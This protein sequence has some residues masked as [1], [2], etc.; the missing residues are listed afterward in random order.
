VGVRPTD[1]RS[2]VEHSRLGALPSCSHQYNRRFA[3]G[4]DRGAA[5]T[6]PGTLL[7]PEGS[8][9]RA[10]QLI[11]GWRPVV[12][13]SVGTVRPRTARSVEPVCGICRRDRPYL[14]NCTV[15]AS[16]C[17]FLVKARAIESLW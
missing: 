3:G 14:E 4:V 1:S 8:G 17:A 12:D 2:W 16:I 11:I 6:R 7:G 15:D 10:A 9:H 5:G 13:L